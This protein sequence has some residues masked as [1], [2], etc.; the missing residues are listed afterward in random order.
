[1]TI[2]YRRTRKEMP[3]DEE[4]VEHAEEE[5]VKLNMLTIPVEIK[6][7]D[8]RIRALHCLQAKLVEKEG[9]DRMYP[10]PV[11]GSDFDIQADAVI[12]AIGQYVDKD[13]LEDLDR[14]EWTRRG[15][16]HV[17]MA[18][19][20]TAREDVFAVGDAVTGPATVIEAIG[21][22]KRAANAIDRYLSG[23]PQLNMPPVP[24]RRAITEFIEIPASAKMVSVAVAPTRV[25]PRSRTRSTSSSVRTPPAA[26]TWTD[27]MHPLR[28]KL[29]SLSVAPW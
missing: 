11:E 21:G 24:V 23:L 4:E 29:R 25:T 12:P 7:Q 28:I 17:N 18:S 8:G 26:L 1:M 16:I 14:V 22:G 15:T 20:T 19:M 5:G 13:C 3:A 27:S 2:A 6:G 9:S 10:K